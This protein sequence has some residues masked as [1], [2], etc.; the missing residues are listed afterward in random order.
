[1][2]NEDMYKSSYIRMRN[3]LKTL[4]SFIKKEKVELTL[5]EK[6]QILNLRPTHEVELDIVNYSL[7]N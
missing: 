3:F 5:T 4:S 2:Y 1:M 7:I 6:M